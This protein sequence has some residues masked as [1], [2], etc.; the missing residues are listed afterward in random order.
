M[1]RAA[2]SWEP[3][4]DLGDPVGGSSTLS[5]PGDWDLSIPW[6]GAQTERDSGGPINDAERMSSSAVATARTE[7]PGR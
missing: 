6:K 2:H 5:M 7:S 4:D 3:S 1:S